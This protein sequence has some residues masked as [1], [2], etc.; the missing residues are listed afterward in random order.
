MLTHEFKDRFQDHKLKESKPDL[1]SLYS[2]FTTLNE[3]DNNDSIVDMSE[4]SECSEF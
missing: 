4:F 1:D 2:Q 3:W